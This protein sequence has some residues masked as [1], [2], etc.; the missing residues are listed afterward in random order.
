MVFGKT[1]DFEFAEVDR[2]AKSPL[3]HFATC[4]EGA[5]CETTLLAPPKFR[6]ADIGGACPFGSI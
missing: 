4:G 5:G 1:L 2:S 3:L 6:D